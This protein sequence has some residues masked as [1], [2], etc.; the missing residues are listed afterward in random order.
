MGWCSNTL[1]VVYL[2]Y[3]VFALTSLERPAFQHRRA[4]L[5][6]DYGP[7][8]IGIAQS[9][10]FGIV[11]PYGTIRNTGD[12]ISVAN[13]VLDLARTWS[14]S[15]IVLGVPLDSDGI[16][17]YDVKNFNGQLCL[18]FSQVLSAVSLHEHNA[19]FRT[20]LFDERFT[21]KEAK[22][23]LQYENVKG[24]QSHYCACLVFALHTH[25]T[26]YALYILCTKYS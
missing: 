15:E 16:L 19:K 12:L 14:V 3:C 5:S 11:E 20:V 18:N 23:R 2:L 8:I 25:I 1:F 26:T 10:Y 21:T 9:N 24:N 17:H 7:R 4:R 13:N 22:L 6:I